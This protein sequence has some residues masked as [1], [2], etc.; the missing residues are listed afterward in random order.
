MSNFNT[1]DLVLYITD[2]W[3]HIFYRIV[4][5][6][7]VTSDYILV[8]NEKFTVNN[9]KAFKGRNTIEPLTAKNYKMYLE[10]EITGRVLDLYSIPTS[11]ANRALITIDK[12]LELS[13]QAS[14]HILDKL[15]NEKSKIVFLLRLLESYN[16]VCSLKDEELVKNNIVYY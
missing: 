16:K 1:K 8:N 6:T 10:H 5:I 15:P 13:L 14:K 2:I 12:S 7:K 9:G 4:P 11:K 3:G